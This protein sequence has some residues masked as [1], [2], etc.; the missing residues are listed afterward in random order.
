MRRPRKKI[1]RIA[2]AQMPV[3][4]QEPEANLDRAEA[5][6][7]EAADNGADLAALPEYFHLPARQH[8]EPVPGPLTQRF[9][10]LARELRLHVVLGSIG[11][12]AGRHVYNTACLLDDRGRLVGTYRKRFLWWTERSNT[13]AGRAAPVFET[14]LGRIGLALCWDLAFPEHFRDLALSGAQIVVCPAFWQAGDRYGRLTSDQLRRVQPLAKA[15]DF[16][17][18]TCAGARAAEN[19]IALAF[20]N[21][22]GR[23]EIGGKLNQLIGQSQVVL[24]F[25]GVIAHARS[26]PALLMADIDLDLVADAERSY[27]LCEDARSIRGRRR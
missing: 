10:D 4:W 5:I 6:L 18:N 15:E 12:K 17:V 26:R 23:T 8:A 21:G 3:R 7:R 14:G 27:G 2:L 24:P 11:E 13:T 1:I 20:V 19:G 16:F 9:G 25:A 22:V